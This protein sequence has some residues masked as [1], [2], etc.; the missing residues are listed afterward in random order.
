VGEKMK[1]LSICLLMA[2]LA[3]EN[4]K[5]EIVVEENNIVQEDVDADNDGYLGDEDCDE[6]S[7][8]IHL[9]A[10]EVCDGLDNDCDGEI[11]EGSKHLLF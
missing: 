11:D 5:K 10:P 6:T 4:S 9:G 3:C 7:S 2:L 8:L 1:Q